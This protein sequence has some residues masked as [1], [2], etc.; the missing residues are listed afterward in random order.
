MEDI[1]SEN[2]IISE[3]FCQCD[4]DNQPLY[5]ND[6]SSLIV[7]LS[8]KEIPQ[9]K[10]IIKFVSTKQQTPSVN[11]LQKKTKLK[12]NDSSIDS[13]NSNNGRWTKEEQKRFAKAVLKYGNDWKKIQSHISSRNLTQVRSHAQKFLM[14][15]KEKDNIKKF[16]LDQNLNWTKTINFLMA[17]LNYDELKNILFSVEQFR[18]RSCKKLK[19]IKI[20]KKNKTE[21]NNENANGF[22]KEFYNNE[23]Q[24]ENSIINNKKIKEE[25]DEKEFQKFIEVFN[26]SSG[27]ITLNSSF[28]ENSQK[29]EENN[30]GYTLS[31]DRQIKYNNIL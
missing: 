17:K 14:K 29:G 16:G 24:E 3:L 30:F 10:P 6:S 26:C 20:T 22:N 31:N 9:I 4:Q 15:L 8:Q 13:E 2:S 12:H 21:E 5:K 19:M 23:I 7:E 28:E 11:F 27:D 1:N 25:E 18:I